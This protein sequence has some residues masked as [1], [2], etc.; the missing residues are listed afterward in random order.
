MC[1]GLTPCEK[2]VVQLRVREAALVV[3]GG[4]RE[5]GRIPTD[6]LVNRWSSHPPILNEPRAPS[7]FE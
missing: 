7:Y 5:E 6:E 2:G 1:R 3:R 4:Q